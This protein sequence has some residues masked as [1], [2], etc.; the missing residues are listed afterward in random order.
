MFREALR[1]SAAC[2]LE[3]PPD[4]GLN[5]S[6]NPEAVMA[7]QAEE[8]AP[9]LVR[10]AVRHLFQPG[11]D[12]LALVLVSGALVLVYG[13][14]IVANSPEQEISGMLPWQNTPFR[15]P[16][17]PFGIGFNPLSTAAIMSP[18]TS[19]RCRDCRHGVGK[20][21][22]CAVKLAG[23]TQSSVVPFTRPLLF[24]T[25]ETSGPD[26]IGYIA[27][28]PDCFAPSALHEDTLVPRLSF[29]P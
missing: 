16:K 7:E 17:A 29:D 24:Q 12:V 22:R 10:I 26:T 15:S 1:T 23:A 18:R 6:L 21:C 13:A 4:P 11:A 20:S 3:K 19:F 28:L 27:A 2:E 14:C 9:V 5:P 8:P 25:L